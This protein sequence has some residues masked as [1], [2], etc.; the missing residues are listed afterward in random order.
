MLWR[1]VRLPLLAYF[2]VLLLAMLFEERLIYFPLK[3]PYGD[4]NPVGLTV[5]DAQFTADDGTRLHG[6]YAPHDE[7]LAY[8]LF[9]HGNAGNVTDRAGVLRMLHQEVGVAVLCLD[10]RGYGK[11][12]GGPSEQ[13]VLKD[14]RAARQWL[15]EKAGIQECEIVLLGRSLGSGVAVDLTTDVSPRALL[16]ECAYTSMPDVAA[17][18][19]PFLPVRSLM[20]TRLDSLSKIASYEGPLLQC[21]GTA[22]EVIPFRLGKQ[23]FDASTSS[24]KEFMELPGATHNE[25]PPR[26]HYERMRRFL[27]ESK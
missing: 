14:A 15:A 13:G 6:W 7:P 25:W 17:F 20:D 1:I 11:S 19:Y 21:H 2:I 5:E 27:E 12:E 9:L 3:F 8:V 16:L 24:R 4:W 18:H 26:A 22:D 23:L 10:Y